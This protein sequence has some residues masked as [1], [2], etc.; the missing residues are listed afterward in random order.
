MRL[1]ANPIPLSD[2]YVQHR[3]PTIQRAKQGGEFMPISKFDEY[4][5]PGHTIRIRIVSVG[6]CV[7]A[8]LV[9]GLTP[10]VPAGAASYDQANYVWKSVKVGGGGFTPGIVFSH[11][12]RGL[13]Y[14]RTDIGGAYR[15]D[16]AAK[17][18]IPLQD[19]FAEANYYGIESIAPD[20]VD[21]NTVYAAAGT[22]RLW[23]AAILRSHDRGATWKIVPVSF[24]MG[25]NEDGRGLGERLA[26]D[27]NATSILYF[28]SRNDGLQRSID[29]GETW[30]KVDAFPVAGRGMPSGNQWS[31]A[32]LSFVVFDPASG[33]K[34]SMT[35][36]IFVGVADDGAQHLFR[37]D[38][39]GAHWTAVAGGPD[40]ALRP[41]QAQIDAKGILYIT[42]CDGVGPTGVK[43]GAVY[44]LDTHSGDWTDITPDKTPKDKR[45]P[46]GYMGLS[47]DARKP[48]TL[49]VATMNR[50]KPRD[51]IWRSTDGG[52]HWR[53]IRAKTS[54][55]VSATPYLLWGK[56]K[57]DFGWW[58]AA[59]AIDPFDSA[60][61]AYS[62][63]ATIYETKD[64]LNADKGH[65]TSWHPWVE[66]MEETAIIAMANP[67]DGPH[68]ISGFGDIGG[69]VHD[70]LDRS[71][72]S[73][74][75]NPIFTNTNTIDYAGMAP[76]VMVR[77]GRP[78]KDNTPGHENSPL[79]SLAYSVDAGKSWN[80]ISVPPFQGRDAQGQTQVQRFD[81][82]GDAAIAVS[83][84]GKTLIVMTPVPMLTRDYGK[85]WMPVQGLPLWGQAV[86]DRVDA[87]RFYSY[88]LEKRIV[89]SSNDGGASFTPLA[90]SGLPG[91]ASSD[92]P[93]SPEAPWPFMATPG[94]AGDLW[95]RSRNR[96]L[97]S[98]D[99]GASFADVKTG[100]DAELLTFGKAAPG[101]DYPALFMVA[102][103]DGLRGIW[104]SDDMGTSWVRINDA[105]HEYGRKYRCIVGD[106]RVFG[107][108]YVGTDGRGI[109]YGDPVK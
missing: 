2:L 39:A 88:D 61:V 73:M 94:K 36:S 26:V 56:P 15:W 62:T 104:R 69:F 108:V 106:M 40:A 97:H 77:S 96:I 45:A 8:A 68:L 29:S 85:T 11:A 48:G 25:G 16:A 19:N 6:L 54:R 89:L 4:R 82:T 17:R 37:S 65:S 91:D 72:A 20:P 95:L 105:N 81:Q 80:P 41:V 59:L 60:H 12:E 34:G 46:G 9:L 10:T 14:L 99:G 86:A 102:G 64:F 103:K 3:V 101:K 31:N 58:I 49:V 74:F 107:R 67:P 109:V 33:A 47:L 53:D 78:L 22:Y 5:R 35:K 76:N 90:T 27:P 66:G 13:A 84:D 28:G 70:N 79:I 23:D 100:L 30:A 38:D 83:A 32:G 24:R 55:D 98:S 52:K 57:A 50:N 21:P 87:K 63:G 1:P 43:D 71:P 18:W 44:K 92:W 7:F 93:A 42:Y 75:T 51:T